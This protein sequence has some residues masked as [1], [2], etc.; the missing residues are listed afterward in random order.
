MPRGIAVRCGVNLYELA[1][2]GRLVPSPGFK[3]ETGPILSSQTIPDW[4][5]EDVGSPSARL[6]LGTLR[7]E[8]L[9]GMVGKKF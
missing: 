8:A 7:R 4:V 2:N 6:Y 5:W 3:R 9:R 1:P